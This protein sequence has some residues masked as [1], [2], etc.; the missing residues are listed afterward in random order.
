MA[1][2]QTN[3]VSAWSRYWRSAQLAACM[4][5][6]DGNYAGVI[7]SSW[8]SYFENAGEGARI[9]DLAT[10]NGAI[11]LIAAAV[12]R[13]KN[14]DFEVHGVDIAE[15]APEAATRGQ[16]ELLEAIQF[17]SHTSIES[18]PFDDKSVDVISSQ[19]GIEYAN[20]TA[21]LEECA[22]VLKVK[23]R[24]MMITH[25]IDSVVM[26]QTEIDLDDSQLLIESL[27]IV[28]K[29]KQLLEVEMSRD[30]IVF[31]NE[32]E[33]AM[34]SFQQAA[35]QVVQ[36]VSS[37]D[38][39]QIDFLNQV[40]HRF[41]QIYQQR[42]EDGL[43]VA[44]ENTLDVQ[45]EIDAH[46]SRLLDLKQS[47]LSPVDLGQWKDRMGGLGFELVADEQVINDLGRKLGHRL[48][49]VMTTT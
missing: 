36:I 40:M 12:S 18:L 23:G 26:K 10:G 45:H 5:G 30:S 8:E 14:R 24:I 28:N 13:D 41:G 33:R 43:P 39:K 19:Y 21:V 31:D 20:A 11:A 42:N 6:E 38:E 49:F 29:F 37:R 3:T 16:E 15:L 27:D 25:S 46:R 34:T 4:G 47:A 35:A 44:L 2:K 1:E 7:R 48:E 32:P 9:L 17:H 22:R